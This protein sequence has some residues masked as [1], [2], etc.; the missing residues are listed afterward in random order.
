MSAAAKLLEVKPVIRCK[1]L[2]RVNRFV[3]EVQVK[4]RVAK[5]HLFNTGR[6]S[7]YLMRGREGFCTKNANPGKLSYRLF[8]V[9]DDG[10]GA[11][12]DTYLQ[13]KAFEKALKLIPRFMNYKISRRNI[14]VGE[15][16]LDY[17][18][19]CGDGKLLLEVKSAVLRIDG[20]ASY[21]D[22]PSIRA[23]KQLRDLIKAVEEGYR[24]AIVFIAALPNISAFKPNF[25]AD[26]ELCE[27]LSEAKDQ[28]VEVGAIS[29]I[30]DPETSL[31]YLLDP[32]L[33]VE[34]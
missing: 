33:R 8:S 19:E 20:Y 17:I 27:L 6:L 7:D 2:R 9:V 22:C 13:L 32:E 24:G 26:R 3:V 1:I 31:I 25:Q 10:L 16:I 14:R 21:P 18:L 15:S 29:M 30:Y 12:L 34:L 23:K 5:A 28:G 11:V 4:G